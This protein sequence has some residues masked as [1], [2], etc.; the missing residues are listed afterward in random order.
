MAAVARRFQQ[1]YNLISMSILKIA[2]LG[3]P[4]LRKEARPLDRVE[5]RTAAF[6]TLIDDM[7]ET[8]NEYRGIGLAAT[9]VHESVR[10]LVARLDAGDDEDE[11]GE[12]IAL[13]NP[14]II[15]VGDEVVEGWEGCLSIPEIRGRVLR[16]RDIKVRAI[17]RKGG[18]IE[19]DLHDFPARVIQHEADHL[20]GF[21][22]IDRMRSFASLTFLEEYSRFWTKDSRNDD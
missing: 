14:E 12:P 8:M 20:D 22:F 9:Q 21:L 19:L 4:V 3:H 10:L 1:R 16:P 2:R 15:L 13:I 18:R 11:A 7:T 17:D 5:I 6:Q